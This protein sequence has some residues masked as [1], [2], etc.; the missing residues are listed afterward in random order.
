ML[1]SVARVSRR[2]GFRSRLFNSHNPQNYLEFQPIAQ[3]QGTEVQAP[4][5]VNDAHE[6]LEHLLR[7]AVVRP[8]EGSE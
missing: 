7:R 6:R 5:P 4:Q 8:R 3:I 2:G 1:R